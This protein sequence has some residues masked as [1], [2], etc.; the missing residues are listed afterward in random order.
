MPLPS[1]YGYPAYPPTPSTRRAFIT[2]KH[3]CQL[4][5]HRLP[6]YRRSSVVLAISPRGSDINEASRGFFGLFPFFPSPFFCFLARFLL[7]CRAEGHSRTYGLFVSV[8]ADVPWFTIMAL[9][10]IF[11][12]TVAFQRETAIFCNAT[13]GFFSFSFFFPPEYI[14]VNMSTEM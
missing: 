14:L 6:I 7:D 3:S 5:V 4:K 11:A 9:A 13:L 10:L 2:A 8:H 1:A 12:E